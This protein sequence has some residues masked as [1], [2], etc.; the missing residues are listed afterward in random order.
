MHFGHGG[1]PAAGPSAFPSSFPVANPGHAVR[2][3]AGQAV[4]VGDRYEQAEVTVAGARLNDAGT[5]Q[6]PQPD[7]VAYRFVDV[8]L[9]VKNL[10]AVAAGYGPDDV[11]LSDSAGHPYPSQPPP[12]GQAMPDVG[13][14]QPGETVEGYVGFEVPRSASGL[15][16]WVVVGSSAVRIPIE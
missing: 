12:V 2:G 8:R 11:W 7:P 4:R 3:T 16:V 5:S 15:E 1:A 10:S 6:V 9:R 13:E 14:V